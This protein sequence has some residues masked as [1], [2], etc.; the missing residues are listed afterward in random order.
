MNGVV[1][2]LVLSGV[3]GV[4]GLL[5]ANKFTGDA[6]IEAAK[7]YVNDSY[8]LLEKYD[9]K[10]KDLMEEIKSLESQIAN[11]TEDNELLSKE[12]EELNEEIKNIETEK[13]NLLE[14]IAG[15]EEQIQSEQTTTFG[16][17]QELQKANLEITNANKKVEE[18]KNLIIEKDLSKFNP[19]NGEQE[20]EVENRQLEISHSGLFDW[21]EEYYI[22]ED[23]DINF[24]TQW[25]DGFRIVPKGGIYK[26]TAIFE[27]GSNLEFIEDGTESYTPLYNDSKSK[28]KFIEARVYDDYTLSELTKIIKYEIIWIK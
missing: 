26:F 15:L 10:Q 24:I 5:M 20:I 12:I 7:A 9:I 11:K 27:D 18:L 17:K 16:I 25:R 3:I 4:S 14:S 1:K 2:A 6:A 13:Q 22:D 28:V 21:D 19:D 8:S 23:S